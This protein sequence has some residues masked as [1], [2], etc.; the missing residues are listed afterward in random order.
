MSVCEVSSFWTVLLS[1]REQDFSQIIHYL[2]LHVGPLKFWFQLHKLVRFLDVTVVSYLFM[3]DNCYGSLSY[4]LN[5]YT[6]EIKT[7]KTQREKKENHWIIF[8]SL[9]FER[10]GYKLQHKWLP[11]AKILV[12][13]KTELIILSE[14]GYISHRKPYYSGKTKTKEI[15]LCTCRMEN[16]KINSVN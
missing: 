11:V 4:V 7:V 1:I 5:K 13:T 6:S 10:L 8:F 12:L 15:Y 9:N 14:H 16:F 3:R 2:I